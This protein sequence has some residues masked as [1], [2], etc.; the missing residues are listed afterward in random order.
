MKIFKHDNNSNRQTLTK[1][2]AI[3]TTF[4]TDFYR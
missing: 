3:M 1:R 2:I 4:L